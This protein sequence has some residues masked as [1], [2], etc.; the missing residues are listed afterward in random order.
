[1]LVYARPGSI[2]KTT[3]LYILSFIS[4]YVSVCVCVRARAGVCVW[5]CARARVHMQSYILECGICGWCACGSV[6]QSSML[7]VAF[8]LPPLPPSK[9]VSNYVI[10]AGL[11]THRTLP[12]C[13]FQVL[14]L[15]V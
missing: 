1:M 14:R 12:V 3:E 5:V 11:K 2:L 10:L 13:A 15:K 4:V 9:A 8:Y 6:S 7:T